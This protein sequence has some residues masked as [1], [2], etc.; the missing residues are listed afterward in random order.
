MPTYP[1]YSFSYPTY[2]FSM[3]SYSIPTYDPVPMYN[4]GGSGGYKPGDSFGGG[5]GEFANIAKKAKLTMKQIIGIVVGSVTGFIG[6]LG[7]L[8]AAC[9]RKMRRKKRGGHGSE[10]E[11]YPVHGGDG[12]L[13]NVPTMPYRPGPAPT[14]PFEQ[15]PLLHGGNYPPVSF[16][17]LY[18]RISAMLISINFRCTH[19]LNTTEGM[20]LRHF[21]RML[22]G[23]ETN[24]TLL[25]SLS[26]VCS[27]ELLRACHTVIT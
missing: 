22:G 15:E 26:A 4:A 10:G 7:G 11:K 23:V 2:S 14:G 12:G 8:W 1:D 9:K 6:F 17:D 27:L 3:P 5:G 20:P 13:G 24:S 16:S 19:L 25:W 18:V 21:D